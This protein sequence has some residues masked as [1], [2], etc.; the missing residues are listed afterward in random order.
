MSPSP[1]VVIDFL[2]P[3]PA[4]PVVVIKLLIKSSHTRTHTHRGRKWIQFIHFSCFVNRIIESFVG[5][6]IERV[7]VWLIL[8]S[9]RILRHWLELDHRRQPEPQN[10]WNKGL[11]PPEIPELN[12]LL[13]TPAM[14]CKRPPPPGLSLQH[15]GLLVFWI[16]SKD[17]LPCTSFPLSLEKSTEQEFPFYAIYRLIYIDT[18]VCMCVCVLI[19]Q[20]D[21]TGSTW[22]DKG[23]MAGVAANNRETNARTHTQRG[24]NIQYWYLLIS[25]S[26]PLFAVAGV[27]RNVSASFNKLFSRTNPL[28]PPVDLIIVIFGHRGRSS[29][30]GKKGKISTGGRRSCPNKH[31]LVDEK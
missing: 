7:L 17:L 10:K 27:G 2:F 23:K 14:T 28:T 24:K 4:T 6:F 18:R 20:M 26:F 29:S 15:C 8:L 3:N 25:F 19:R 1:P 22:Q 12:R 21:G 5:C 16:L 13:V 9:S 31:R 11:H 30:E